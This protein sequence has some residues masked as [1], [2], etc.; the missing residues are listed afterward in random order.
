[1]LHIYIPSMQRAN[2]Q[3]TFSR[4]PKKLQERTKIVVP[5]EEYSAYAD[6][7]GD[8]YV[9]P[10]KVKGIAPTR[11]WILNTATA[12]GQR[13]IVMLDDDVILYKRSDTEKA[14]SGVYRILPAAPADYLQ[15]FKWIESALKRVPHCGW[16]VR[17]NDFDTEEEIRS[18]G[19][20]MHCLAYDLKVINELNARFS[21]GVAP[22]HVMDDFNMTLQLLTAGYRNEISLIWRCAPSASNSRGG[23]ST[24]RTVAIHN[25]SA[26][27]MAQRF[28]DY[29]SIR[30]KKNW[31]GMEG[32]PMLDITAQWRKAY[33]KSKKKV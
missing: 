10:T 20:M 13:H 12:A 6:K 15:A 19:R 2:I 4:L 7:W 33:E 27:R 1:L 8:G 16:G 26:R 31:K 21:K 18:P 11:D 24:W 30:E 14:P 29:V 23:A 9:L 25:E 28:P 32:E 3:R 5:V 17:F 22:T